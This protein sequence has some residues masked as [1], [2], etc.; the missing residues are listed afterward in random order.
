[1]TSLRA[2][3][4]VN[5]ATPMR[6]KTRNRLSRSEGERAARAPAELNDPPTQN[7][8]PNQCISGTWGPG[9]SRAATEDRGR[10]DS[11]SLTDF[12]EYSTGTDRT[13]E[14]GGPWTVDRGP[15]TADRVP[16]TVHRSPFTVHR[17]PFTVHQLHP[18]PGTSVPSALT[19]RSLECSRS[20]YVLERRNF[21]PP[22]SKTMLSPPNQGCTST[23]RSRFTMYRRWMRRNCFGSSWPSMLVA[24]ARIRWLDGPTCNRT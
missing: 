3:S 6:A 9:R 10:S 17:S 13:L 14:V 21:A 4:L 11:T 24:V 23:T 16:R 19:P 22:L 5:R 18:P 2:G 12:V 15:C 20:R 7:A 1:M 8:A